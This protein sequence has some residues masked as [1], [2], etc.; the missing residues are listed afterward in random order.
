[1]G[2]NLP[3][4]YRGDSLGIAAPFFGSA[5]AGF[6][7]CREDACGHEDTK[8]SND[9]DGNKH[10]L[11][12]APRHK[13]FGTNRNGKKRIEKASPRRTGKTSEDKTKYSIFPKLSTDQH[14]NK[15]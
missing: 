2:V 11:P 14:F 4:L 1:M 12:N 8:R 10:G 3:I 7:T 15:I 9:L 5:A 13:V 6:R